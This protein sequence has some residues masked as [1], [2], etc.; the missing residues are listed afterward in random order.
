[1]PL[2]KVT[3]RAPSSSRVSVT[4]PGTSRVCNAP[5]SRSASHAVSGRALMYIS[6]QIEAID[7]LFCAYASVLRRRQLGESCACGSGPEHVSRSLKR[8]GTALCR[9]SGA[10]C[11]DLGGSGQRIEVRKG[12]TGGAIVVYTT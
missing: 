8:S 6:L 9:G 2:P 4:K 10:R 1:M 3:M 11:G 12:L 5:T 7:L